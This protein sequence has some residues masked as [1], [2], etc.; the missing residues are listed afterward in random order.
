MTRLSYNTEDG[1]YIVG[2]VGE[3]LT[4]DE[5]VNELVRPIMLAAGYHHDAISDALGDCEDKDDDEEYTGAIPI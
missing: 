2:I 1:E 5:F 4:A 3:N